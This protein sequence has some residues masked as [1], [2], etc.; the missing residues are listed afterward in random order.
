[1]LSFIILW[2]CIYLYQSSRWEKRVVQIGT[3]F[4]WEK[5]LYIFVQAN[6]E[7]EIFAVHTVLVPAYRGRE[8]WTYLY[9]LPGREGEGCT[10]QWRQ[11]NLNIFAQSK[12]YMQ[13]GLNIIF[14]RVLKQIALLE[15]TISW[16]CSTPNNKKVD[17]SQ[18][19]PSFFMNKAT[20]NTRGVRIAEQGVAVV[21]KNYPSFFQGSLFV[22]DFT[23]SEY[24]AV[25]I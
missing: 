25:Y 21:F 6:G 12:L 22:P 7:R 18:V 8:I 15:E 20:S 19:L 24:K 16:N 17:Y 14:I 23:F 13:T 9:Q 10:I 3:G 4:L 2:I 1:M 5:D 11:T